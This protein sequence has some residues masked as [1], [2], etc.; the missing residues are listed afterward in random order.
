MFSKQ[1]KIV[2]SQEVERILLA[3]NHPEMPKEKP[4]FHLHVKGK[5]SWSWADIEPNW[6]FETREPSVNPWNEVARKKLGGE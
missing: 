2:I 4:I 3:L 5:E 1:E 6:T